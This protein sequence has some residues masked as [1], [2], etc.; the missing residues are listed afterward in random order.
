MRI[1]QPQNDI[2]PLLNPHYALFW[3]TKGHYVQ[4]LLIMLAKAEG[5]MCSNQ[6]AR[7]PIDKNL[8]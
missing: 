3:Q 5:L 2:G 4:K 8:V 7:T 6:G 1:P